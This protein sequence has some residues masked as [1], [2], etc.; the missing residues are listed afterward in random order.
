[1]ISN[2]VD[3]GKR[4]EA[5]V[6]EYLRKRGY[7]IRA[8]NLHFRYGELDIVAEKDGALV[9]VEVKSQGYFSQIEPELAVTPLKL[10]KLRR[11]IALLLHD[12][13]SQRVHF[14]TVQLD[15][16]G[17]ARGKVVSHIQ[18]IESA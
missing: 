5:I 16:I 15:V 13:Y 4:G 11:C 1:M 18:N 2:T 17:V 3:R 7:T 14:K 6:V 10:L 8:T 12:L 9:V